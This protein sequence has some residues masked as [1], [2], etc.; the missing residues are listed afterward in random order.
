MRYHDVVLSTQYKVLPIFDSN[1]HRVFNSEIDHDISLLL[2]VVHTEKEDIFKI[3]CY[4]IILANGCITCV[5]PYHEN[6]S[7]SIYNMI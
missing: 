1:C 2:S 5:M 7:I 3:S 4:E 6:G